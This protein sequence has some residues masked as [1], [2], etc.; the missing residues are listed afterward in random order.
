MP[1][2]YNKRAIENDRE[3]NQPTIKLQIPF[4]SLVEAITNLDIKQKQQLWKILDEEMAVI[5]RVNSY[6]NATNIVEMCI[7]NK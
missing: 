5:E 4:E 7:A 6:F 2:L 1:T 3:M